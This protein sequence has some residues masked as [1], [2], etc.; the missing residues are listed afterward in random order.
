MKQR[1]EKSLILAVVIAPLS[2]NDGLLHLC[3]SIKHHIDL[4]VFYP[5]CL[6]LFSS[7]LVWGDSLIIVPVKGEMDTNENFPTLRASVWSKN[8]GGGPP[9]PLPWINHSFISHVIKCDFIPYSIVREAKSVSYW[10]LGTYPYSP[11]MG[12]VTI[13]NLF[14][15]NIVLLFEEI[16]WKYK[17]WPDIKIGPVRYPWLVTLLHCNS[18][19]L[20][21][22]LFE[23]I[24]VDR[25]LWM[26]F[27]NIIMILTSM[28]QCRLKSLG[29]PLF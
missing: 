10:V 27:Y 17:C 28:F 5:P 20:S 21:D 11:S 6:F 26:A 19:I 4:R 29:I 13:F 7:F 24:L 1:S 3:V 23:F 16:L 2:P 22:P 14:S 8:K 15:S 25:S 9:G 12:E 18:E